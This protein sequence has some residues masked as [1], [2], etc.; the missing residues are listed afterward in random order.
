MSHRPIYLDYAAA[1]PLD[2]RVFLAMEPYF[3][4]RFYNPSSLYLDAKYVREDYEQ[5]RHQIAQTIGAKQHEIVITAG[6]T[7]SINLALSGTIHRHGGSIVTSSIEHHAVLMTAREHTCYEVEADSRGVVSAQAV[8]DAVRD[9]TTIVSIGFVNNELGTVQSIRDIA[10][11][12]DQIRQ[13]RLKEGN[14]TP[15]YFHTDASQAMGFIDCSVSRLGVDLMTLNSAKCYGPKQVGVLWVSAGVQLAPLIYGGGQEGGLR[16]G[17]ENVASVIGCAEAFRLASIDRKSESKRLAKL[18]DD[19]QCSLQSTIPD[20]VINGHPK[21]RAPHILHVSVAGLDGERAVF[22]LDENGVLASTGSACASNDGTRSHVLSAVKM[23]NELADG[24]LR[25]SLGR[26]T[27]SDDIVQA[28]EI[29]ARVV[30][31]ERVR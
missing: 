29:I 4:E 1:T 8:R 25:F 28:S 2:R 23:S 20:I 30:A 3:S 27:S 26:V 6:A 22:S 11:E 21:R 31:K 10:T 14:K 19:L 16:S 13:H 7:E 5:A 17:T 9:D 18:R 12:L 15:L 24:S